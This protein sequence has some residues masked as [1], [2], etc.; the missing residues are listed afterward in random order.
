MCGIVGLVAPRLAPQDAA[1]CT[2]IM[3]AQVSHRG[4]DST[5]FWRAPEL[6]TYLGHQRLAVIDLSPAGHQPMV[7]RSGRYTLSFNGEIYNHRALREQLR[8]YGFRGRSDT[9]VLLAAFD[10]WGLAATLGAVNGMFAVSLVDRVSGSL[11][12][13]RDPLGEKPLY[14]GDVEGVGFVFA[15]ELKAI[16]ALPGF[17]A[18]LNPDALAGYLEYSYVPSPLC[19]YEGLSKLEPGT[20]L[21]VDLRTLG[22]TQHRYWS[23]QQAATEGLENQIAAAPDAVTGQLEGLLRDAVRLR[24]SADVP[25]GVFLSGGIDSSLVAALAQDSL[26]GGLRTFSIG[27]SEDEYNEAVYASHVARHLQTV[28]TEMYVTPRDAMSVIP[29]LPAIYDEPFSD[30][31]QLPTYLVSRLAR[32]HVT[33]TL[34]GDGGDELFAGYTRYVFG[35]QLHRMLGPLPRSARFALA[36]G[37]TALTPQQWQL[38][39]AWFGWSLPASLRQADFG[40]K[41]HKLADCVAFTS[42][43][44]LYRRLTTH[45][46]RPL[47]LVPGVEATVEDGAAPERVPQLT[48]R[49][50]YYDLTSYL[51][52]DI[53]VKL[54][55]ASMAV[56]L[57]ARVPFLDPRVVEYAWRVPLRLKLQGGE[58]KWI[59]RQLLYRYVPERLVQRPKMG[60]AVPIGRWMRHELR[61][62]AESLLDARRLRDQG[63]FDVATIR[64]TWQE[65]LSGRR[66]WQ[67]K[68]WN[69]LMF[70]AWLEHAG[71]RRTEERRTAPRFAERMA[72]APAAGAVQTSR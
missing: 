47:P 13:I 34:S 3:A 65:H 43:R 31:S 62:W 61:D 27:F 46:R 39:Y 66:N 29:R 19:I 51:P 7:S 12:L 50:M 37:M 57:E 52:D 45:W 30:S 18:D 6:G 15:S 5:G 25:V 20:V 53:L 16:A 49:M 56:G 69:L 42:G 48:E 59:L 44:D 38:L 4:P 60:F 35:A 41:L 67:H 64:H 40:D 24:L 55:R 72:D 36:R 17:A 8:D 1:R 70:Q 26:G 32:S 63:F 68:L 33:V 14:Y 58:G 10:V 28:H 22:R 2:E 9:E 54:D 11:H 71:Q 21:S 23:L